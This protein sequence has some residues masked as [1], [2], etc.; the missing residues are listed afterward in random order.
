VLLFIYKTEAYALD[1]TKLMF[2]ISFMKFP[3]LKVGASI[4]G[5]EIE[6]KKRKEKVMGNMKTK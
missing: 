3:V 2:F 1:Y 5:E 6:K 4:I